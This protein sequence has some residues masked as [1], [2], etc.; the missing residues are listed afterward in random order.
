MGRP[1]ESCGHAEMACGAGADTHA[2]GSLAPS[3]SRDRCTRTSLRLGSSPSSPAHPGGGTPVLVPAP[4]RR[5]SRPAH[6]RSACPRAHTTSDVTRLRL[7]QQED[8]LWRHRLP[9]RFAEEEGWCRSER[10]GPLEPDLQAEHPAR[11]RAHRRARAAR[12][13]LHALLEERPRA[14][15]RASHLGRLTHP[16]STRDD[17]RCSA[18]PSPRRQLHHEVSLEQREHD[19]S[20]APATARS[21]HSITRPAHHARGG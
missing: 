7:L 5:P 20:P 18:D 11:A 17:G 6:A 9:A 2:T 21:V 16:L 4:A 15:A 8:C 10:H 1:T 14:K 12:Q 13:D 3:S 19:P